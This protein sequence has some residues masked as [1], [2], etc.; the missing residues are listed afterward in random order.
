MRRR[1]RKKRKRKINRDDTIF[2]NEQQEA[3]KI[4]V[5]ISE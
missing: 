5:F 2:E 1:R 3:G 4:K